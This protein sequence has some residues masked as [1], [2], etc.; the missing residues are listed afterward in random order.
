MNPGGTFFEFGCDDP[1]IEAVIRLIKHNYAIINQRLI[2]RWEFILHKFKIYNA[3]N[4]FRLQTT[5]TN[6][7]SVIKSSGITKT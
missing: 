2:K 4:R 6:K 7:R 5:I 3:D 1:K